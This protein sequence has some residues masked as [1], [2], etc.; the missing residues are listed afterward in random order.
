[1]EGE[2]VREAEFG[3]MCFEGGGRGHKAKLQMAMPLKAA[4]GKYID[5]LLGACRP[6]EPVLYTP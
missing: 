1:M 5:P 4:K 3:V 2:M 6:E